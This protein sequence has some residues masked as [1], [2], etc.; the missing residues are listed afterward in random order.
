MSLLRFKDI[1]GS[2]S[3]RS[4]TY[5]SSFYP[6]GN[7]ANTEFPS[8]ETLQLKTVKMRFQLMQECSYGQ[9]FLVVGDDPILGAWDP[10]SAIPLKWSEGNLWKAQLDVPIDKTIEFKFILKDP[11]T[12]E[13]IWHPRPNR[14]FRTWE[15][16]MIFVFEDWD[17][18][19]GD[20]RILFEDWDTIGRL[21]TWVDLPNSNEK[22]LVV[23]KPLSSCPLSSADVSSIR[24]D[25][26][27]E[28]LAFDT[29]QNARFD[30]E[31]F[32]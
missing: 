28:S 17:V 10:S 27:F 5:E 24:L 11:K 3:C 9:E 29:R 21:Q 25:L 12:G 15:T 30:F 20:C 6:Q 7:A 19:F 4:Y 1:M 13:I 26:L 23:V 31:S 2:V 16:K 18:V 22:K 8:Q 32:D 14:V